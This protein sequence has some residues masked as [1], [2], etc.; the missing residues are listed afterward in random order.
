MLVLNIAD[1]FLDQILDCDQSVRPGIFVKHNRQMGPR[2]AHIRQQIEHTH[3]LRNIERFADQGRDRYRRLFTR[4]QD[5]KHILD[6]D[7]TDHF[8][9]A[10]LIDR[11]AAVARIGKGGDE[12]IKSN[13]IGDRDNIAA[14]HRD[15]ARG[16]IAK[17]E[18]VA[19]HLSFDT[20]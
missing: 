15:I 17:L 5:N 2:T 13:R 16:P 11:K 9:E 3:R 4:R 6:V 12:R 19:E 7:H 14:R 1:N 10:T 20:R 18:E 8:I